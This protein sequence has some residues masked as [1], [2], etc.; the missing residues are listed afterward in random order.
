MTA[1]GGLSLIA[2][3]TSET[4]ASRSFGKLLR[5]AGLAHPVAVK[6]LLAFKPLTIADHSRR[7]FAHRLY[8]FP[9]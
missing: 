1:R 9:D 5:E 4:R 6:S 3:P 8:P 2:H 7:L